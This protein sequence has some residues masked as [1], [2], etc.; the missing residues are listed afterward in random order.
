LDAALAMPGPA[1]IEAVVD[2]YT[3]MLPPKINAK[4]AI[5][6]SESLLRGEPDRM[7]IAL[8]AAADTVRQII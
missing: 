3:A 5:H 8:T 7:R 1:V 4:Q 6:F 2:P